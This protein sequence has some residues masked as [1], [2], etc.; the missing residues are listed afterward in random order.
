[1]TAISGFFTDTVLGP[2]RPPA[3]IQQWDR[4]QNDPF[5]FRHWESGNYKPDAKIG[6]V[7]GFDA[8]FESG[9]VLNFGETI[10]NDNGFL[11]DTVVFTFNFGEVNSNVDAF[12]DQMVAAS[13]VGTNFKAFNMRLWVGN[14][15]AFTS[16]SV[17]VPEF[18]FLQSSG[19]LKGFN[20]TPGGPNTSVVPTSIPPSG[21]ILANNTGVF[22]SG[23]YQDVSFSNFIY[24]RGQFPAGSFALGTYG[25]LGEDSFTFNFSYDWTDINAAVLISDL[26]PCLSPPVSP[27][28]PVTP[29]PSGASLP[30][31]MVSFWNLDENSPRIDKFGNTHVQLIDNPDAV[32]SGM[33][34]YWKMEE[35]SGTRFDSI[36]SNDLADINTVGQE[37]GKIGNAAN[38]VPANSE[39][40]QAVNSSVHDFGDEDFMF[41]GWFRIDGGASTGALLSKTTVT[42][43]SQGQYQLQYISVSDRIRWIVSNDGVASQIVTANSHDAP[44]KNVFLF[45][46]CWHDSVND[47]I[48]IQINNGSVDSIATAL[49]INQGTAIF[50]IGA[51]GNVEPSSLTTF[52]DGRA[53]EITV[54]NRI[55]TTSER[56]ELYN[57]GS[58]KT[59]ALSGPVRASGVSSDTSFSSQ[60]SRVADRYLTASGIS[61]DSRLNFG[62][63]D[64]AA[65]AFVYLDSKPSGD[66]PIISKWKGPNDRQYKM[67]YDGVIDRFTFS[68][69]SDG[70]AFNTVSGITF[71]SPALA[72]WYHVYGH[73]NS[74]GN[75]LGMSI[76]NG[77]LDTV[78]HSGGASTTGNN[79][80]EIGGAIL[81][82]GRSTF[83]GR[84]DALGIWSKLL[85]S[86][87]RDTLV[88]VG[89]GRQFPFGLETSTASNINTFWRMNE[90][91]GLSRFDVI[92]GIELT[93]FGGAE[94]RIGLIGSGTNFERGKSQYLQASG[95]SQLAF[96]D[97]DFTVAGRFNFNNIDPT[98]NI[99]PMIS[100]W[101]VAGDNLEYRLSFDSILNGFQFAVASGGSQNGI[102]AITASGVA[103]SG[104]WH[105]VIGEHDSVKNQIRIK[106]DKDVAQS[107]DFFGGVHSGVAPFQIAGLPASGTFFDGGADSIATWRRKLTDA[108]FGVLNNI[109]NGSEWPF[110]AF[111]GQLRN[112]TSGQGPLSP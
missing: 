84:I 77:T 106:V 7:G 23:V 49:G 36:G 88:N 13:S 11:T 79:D 93:N 4:D 42:P 61:T 68:V 67:S 75:Q 101:Q 12:F 65:A 24:L 58:G 70:S 82:T 28:A 62:D 94:D 37:T 32:S 87:E 38:F 21:N 73:H 86:S 72:T 5:G 26:L 95:G 100:K 6:L 46:V 47:T 60:F 33:L 41:A 40:L 109:G 9:T 45:I 22:I 18:H 59:I 104:Q 103:Q 57:S 56:T 90:G 31:G 3:Q 112:P 29:T 27:A 66:M 50:R 71:G 55:L 110:T 111:D 91:S 53:D 39:A 51:H 10:T 16:K 105:L 2:L 8:Q 76:D 89:S 19:W 15:N 35:S 96:A 107:G 83:N 108:E 64:F 99:T 43:A 81:S 30:S 78:I 52:F 25:S 102:V 1:M 97:E 74:S 34:S 48:N 92:K 17:P 85:N 14:V 69:S 20:V 44:A 98:S 63:E 54:F 80:I